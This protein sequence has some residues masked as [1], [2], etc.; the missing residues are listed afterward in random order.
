M[1]LIGLKKKRIMGLI[2]LEN[3]IMY[4]LI[5]LVCVLFVWV[6]FSPF[7]RTSNTASVPCTCISMYNVQCTLWCSLRDSKLQSLKAGIW[8]QWPFDFLP[9]IRRVCACALYHKVSV[10]S[11]LNSWIPVHPLSCLYRREVLTVGSTHLHMS[12]CWCR[13]PLPHVEQLQL[14]D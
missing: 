1:S 3:R 5:Y 6:D 7:L 9:D 14:V 2:R 10:A 4:I 11:R 12:Y 13:V 8:T